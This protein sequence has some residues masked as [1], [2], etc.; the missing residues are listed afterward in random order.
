[1]KKLYRW[2]ERTVEGRLV[3]P[4]DW[5]GE[6]LFDLCPFDRYETVQVAEDALANAIAADQRKRKDLGLYPEVSYDLVLVA[7]YVDS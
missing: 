3:H 6:D 7:H 5:R 1:M 2:Y 4:V